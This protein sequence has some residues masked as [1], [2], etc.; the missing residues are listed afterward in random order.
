VFTSGDVREQTRVADGASEL[1]QSVFGE[2]KNPS[3]LG[4]SRWSSASGSM[5]SA[6]FRPS[7]QE[8]AHLRIRSGIYLQ[9]AELQPKQTRSASG[10]FWIEPGSPHSRC[11]NNF[12][13]PGSGS[14]GRNEFNTEGS[15]MEAIGLLVT[16]EA[17]SGKEADAEHF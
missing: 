15:S 9:S 5:N 16:L 10:S 14:I 2:D 12:G 17:R 7:Q 13:C 8:S 6:G 4:V 11:S 3:R 1:P